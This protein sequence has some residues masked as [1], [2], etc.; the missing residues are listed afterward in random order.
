MPTL[1]T[2]HHKTTLSDAMLSGERRLIMTPRGFRLRVPI[3][4]KP[5]KIETARVSRGVSL[6]RSVE[7]LLNNGVSARLPIGRVAFR[8]YARHISKSM[9]YAMKRLANYHQRH[10]GDDY[11]HL[12]DFNGPRHG[13]W[14]RLRW[15]G[16]IE[17]RPITGDEKPHE[18]RGWW[19]MTGLGL[20][21]LS[22]DKKIPR[23]A[24]TFDGVF[25]AWLDASD[26]IGPKDIHD[27]FNL[28]KTMMIG[29]A[30]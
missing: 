24:V 4:I 12:I 18:V 17:P 21:W 23:G 27:E 28:N 8:F 2:D 19:R 10:P 16:L 11:A 3:P 29:G 5:G 9:L 13:E 20:R 22:G 30:A 26:L 6:M 25:V 1:L 15:W 14:A 7:A